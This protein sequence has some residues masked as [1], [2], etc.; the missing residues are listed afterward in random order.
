MRW[1]AASTLALALASANALAD[2][3]GWL[4]EHMRALM[5]EADIP[6]AVVAV[7]HGDETWL[8]GE[9][10]DVRN[11]VFRV[12]SVSKP[13]TA[14][15]VQLLVE[16]GTIDLH[17]D[18]RGD[19]ESLPVSP[20]L[21]VPL[22]M[23]QLLTHTAGF[24]EKL[25]GQHVREA[26]R[27]KTLASYLAAELPERFIE[28][29]QIVAYNDHHTAL[30]GWILE[31]RSAEPFAQLAERLL[32]ARLGM[33]RTS[34]EQIDLPRSVVRYLVVAGN[35]VGGTVY[36]RDYVQLPPAAGLFTSA[37]DMARYMRALLNAE[38]PGS[39][40]QLRV[41][42]RH[43][44]KL[45][46]RAYGFAEGRSG[47]LRYLY[48]DGQ[49]SGFNARMV[50]V[51]E[52]RFGFFMAHNR[53]IF[54]ALGRVEP[55]GRFGRRLGG[56][57]LERLWPERT[58]QVVEALPAFDPVGKADRYAGTYRT[59]IA[60]R[61]T[62]ER[63]VSLFDEAVL[64]ADPGGVRLAGALYEPAGEHLFEHQNQ[65]GRHIAF[66]EH[67]GAISHLFIGGGAYERVAWWSSSAAMPWVPGLA[68]AVLMF[69]AWRLWPVDKHLLWL[70]HAALV[71]FFP[72]V[73]TL[74]AT[75][76][77]QRFFHGP[78]TLML[79][80]LALPLLSLVGW[81]I[82]VLRLRRPRLVERLLGA[83]AAAVLF[84]WLWHWRLLGYWL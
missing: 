31:Q 71:T 67:A 24:N 55:A 39:D 48:K 75:V 33:T 60:S 69:T 66:R 54:G 17:E 65:P 28:P 52:E 32:F 57:L 81:G 4:G 10:V 6:A 23:H 79:V 44:E 70:S 64:H 11:A 30:A 61:N 34:F 43:H 84:A 7:V 18:L 41:Q 73:A 77:I 26:D 16:A 3:R 20:P 35:G 76:D 58:S 29:G 40:V 63:L 38:L 56:A 74:F 1:R 36:P 47:S 62:W 45:P 78:P 8:L 53:N 46:G 51:P 12:G 14:S 42:F 83:G 22:T 13:V 25:F 82:A 15:L 5:A 72:L 19:L 59:V 2:V 9:G 27:L 49:A 50:L 68:L 21:Q 80:L 37:P